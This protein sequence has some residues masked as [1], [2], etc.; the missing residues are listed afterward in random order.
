VLGLGVI[1]GAARGT[2]GLGGTRLLA[3]WKSGGCYPRATLRPLSPLATYTPFRD[4]T[5][6]PGGPFSLSTKKSI[7]HLTRLDVLCCVEGHVCSLSRSGNAG[8]GLQRA[9]RGCGVGNSGQVTTAVS[10]DSQLVT[11][12]SDS[13][14]ETLSGGHRK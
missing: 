14:E 10:K 13:G 4:M 12:P 1:W 3:L 6:N 5:E 9:V 8:L 11:G 2:E 7:E